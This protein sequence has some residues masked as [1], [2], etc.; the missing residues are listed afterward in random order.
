MKI[1]VI[2][3]RF[4]LNSSKLVCKECGFSIEL[5]EK[6]YVQ[7]GWWPGATSGSS[8]LY[9]ESL[10]E[11]W[12]HLDNQYCGASIKK[13]IATL[14]RMAVNDQRVYYVAILCLTSCL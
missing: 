11:F 10:L 14:N 13:F 5:K 4:D 3:G 7:S 6:Q 12:Y 9:A 2:S 1:Y 8:Y